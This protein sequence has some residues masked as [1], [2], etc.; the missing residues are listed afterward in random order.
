VGQFLDAL[1]IST[2]NGLAFRV[3]CETN[4]QDDDATLLDNPQLFREP[5]ASSLNP[6]TIHV[7]ETRD[8]VPESF[9]VAQQV[10]KEI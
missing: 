4:C 8:A 5:D 1:K 7:K 9:H 3:L 2:I 10:Q 6:S